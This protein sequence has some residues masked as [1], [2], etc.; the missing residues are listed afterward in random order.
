MGEGEITY[1]GCGAEGGMLI[2][3]LPFPQFLLMT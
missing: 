3:P 1:R 2:S